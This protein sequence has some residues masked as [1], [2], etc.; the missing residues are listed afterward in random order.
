MA[1]NIICNVTK[2]QKITLQVYAQNRNHCSFSSTVLFL[3]PE[4]SHQSCSGVLQVP[5]HPVWSSNPDLVNHVSS[6]YMPSLVIFQGLSK[7]HRKLKV[8]EARRCPLPHSADG[9]DDELLNSSTRLCHIRNHRSSF[10]ENLT[11]TWKDEAVWFMF[12]N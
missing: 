1:S 3:F 9:V 7:S 10:T 4:L 6:L 5:F 11:K 2:R 12:H 8:S